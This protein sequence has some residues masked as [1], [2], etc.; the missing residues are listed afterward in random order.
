MLR[1][2]SFASFDTATNGIFGKGSAEACIA[3]R[4]PECTIH[5]TPKGKDGLRLIQ[6]E[7]PDLVILDLVLA[8]ASGLDVLKDIRTRSDVPVIIVSVEGQSHS[9]TP[10]F[11]PASGPARRL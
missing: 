1:A 5:S 9:P 7:L 3:I 2:C 10:S 6:I 8:D 4:W 11:W